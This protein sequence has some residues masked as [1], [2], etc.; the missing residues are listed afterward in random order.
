MGLANPR[1]VTEEGHGPMDYDSIPALS[2]TLR[3]VALRY[4]IKAYQNTVFRPF[5]HHFYRA[6]LWRN[7]SSSSWS[8]LNHAA[9]PGATNRS[10]IFQL[11]CGCNI[12]ASTSLRLLLSL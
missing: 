9:K 1:L 5:I 11:G 8:N 6:S 2:L 10:V 4:Y 7:V 3:A 12:L